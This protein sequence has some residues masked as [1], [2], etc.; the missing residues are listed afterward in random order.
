MKIRQKVPSVKSCHQ[1]ACTNLSKCTKFELSHEIEKKEKL[2][3]RQ[4][5][6]EAMMAL[7]RS[8]ADM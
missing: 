1:I 8:L 5:Q 6:D 2:L 7:Y 3:K 4:N